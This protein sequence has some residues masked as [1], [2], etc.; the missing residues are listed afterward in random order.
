M[1]LMLT[2]SRVHQA[3]GNGPFL[4]FGESGAD[5]SSACSLVVRLIESTQGLKIA[6]CLGEQVDERPNAGP[7]TF[8]EA[9][10]HKLQGCARWQP[11]DVCGG[12]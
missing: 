6:A 10:A 5:E 3:G 4:R 9:A 11:I 2:S 7:G 12:Q 8:E 1:G